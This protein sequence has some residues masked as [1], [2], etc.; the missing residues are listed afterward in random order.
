[1]H[2]INKH[3]KKIYNDELF[4]LRIKKI[5]WSILLP[6]LFFEVIPSGTT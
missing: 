4:F 6:Q 2:A 1:M 3:E 5:I